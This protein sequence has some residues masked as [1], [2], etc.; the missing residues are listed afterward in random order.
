[1]RVPH[2]AALLGHKEATCV[3]FPASTADV[4]LWDTV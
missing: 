4:D 3:M 1:M 2:V